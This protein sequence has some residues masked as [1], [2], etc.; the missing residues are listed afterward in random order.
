MAKKLAFYLLLF[1]ETRSANFLTKSTKFL[2]ESAYLNT[3]LTKSFGFKNTAFY[4]LFSLRLGRLRFSLDRRSWRAKHAN[5][6]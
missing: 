1:F 3:G 4:F 5:G 2:I 6:S